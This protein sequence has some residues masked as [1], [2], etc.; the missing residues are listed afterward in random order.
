MPPQVK[1]CHNP[2]KMKQQIGGII[3]IQ[4]EFIVVKL[5]KNTFWAC[6]THQIK[7]LRHFSH[8]PSHL[9]PCAKG[10]E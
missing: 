3:Y 10:K 4:L 6:K 7:G 1:L 8:T 2:D 5:Y 9:V